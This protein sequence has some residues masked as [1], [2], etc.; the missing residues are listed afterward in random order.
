MAEVE[1]K[2]KKRGE[3]PR[4]QDLHMRMTKSEMNALEMASYRIE[5]NKSDVIRKALKMYFS[6][7][8]ID[9]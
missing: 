1:K 7:M 2:R 5:E 3:E 6:G 9:Y 8:G 4:D